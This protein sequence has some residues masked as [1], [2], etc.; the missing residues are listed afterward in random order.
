MIYLV[1]TLFL[2]SQYLSYIKYLNVL[3][4]IKKISFILFRFHVIPA[5]VF[6]ISLQVQGFGYNLISFRSIQ[7]LPVYLAPHQGAGCVIIKR[8]WLHAIVT[9]LF[10]FYCYFVRTMKCIYGFYYYLSR[11]Y[12]NGESLLLPVKNNWYVICMCPK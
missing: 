11:S 5:E 1:L 9:S 6:G 12:Q 10:N 3:V 8:S 7:V 2:L 4:P